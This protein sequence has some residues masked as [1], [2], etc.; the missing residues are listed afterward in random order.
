MTERI[1]Y[2]PVYLAI[3]LLLMTAV[4]AVMFTVAPLPRAIVYTLFWGAVYGAGLGRCKRSG[5]KTSEDL[6]QLTNRCAVLALLLFLGGFLFSGIEAGFILMLITLQAGRNLVLFTRRDLNFACLT[7]LI[8]LLFGAAKAMAGHFL[9]FMV[10]YALFAIFTFMAD[11]IDVRLCHA[12]GGDRD[13]LT[14]RMNLPVK[15]V[16]LAVMTL[17]LALAI[18]LLVP[19][20]ASP[21]VQAFPSSSEWNYDNRQWKEEAL[22]QR[23][24]D[25]GQNGSGV[26]VSGSAR[27]AAAE[28]DAE[29]VK[30]TGSEYRGFHK[31]LDVTRGGTFMLSNNVVL[32]LQAENALYVRGKVFDSFDGR[33]WE[34]SRS[35]VEKRYD[36]NG[37]FNFGRKPQAGDTLQVFTIK[38]DLPPF[39]FAAYRPVLVSFPGNVIETDGTLAMRVPDRLRKGTIYSVASHVEEVDHHPCSGALTGDDT[40]Q[41]EDRRYVALYP[42]IPDRIGRLAADITRGAGSDLQ[43][44]EAVEAYLRNNYA[45]T[46]DTI[47]IQWRDDPVERFLFDLKAGHCE[48]FA[49]SMVMMLRTLN[50]PARLA[51]GFYVHR[52]NPV[53]G[54]FEVREADGHAWV[55]AYL[56]RYGWVTF[57]PTSGFQLPQRSHRLFVAGTLARYLGDRTKE[58]I[59]KNRNSLWVKF[60]M[61]IRP[62]LMKIWLVITATFAVILLKCLKLGHWF[63]GGGW[64]SIVLLFLAV[65]GGW[66]LRRMLEPAWRMAGLRRKRSGDPRQFLLS[67]YREMERHFGSRGTP[68]ARPMTPLEYELL[69]AGRFPALS[70]KIALITRLFEQAAYGVVPVSAIEAGAALRAFEDIRRWKEPRGKGVGGSDII[71]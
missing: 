17:S 29:G 65:T 24:G 3:F 58:L 68:R 57:E 27:R 21:R 13:L 63:L 45:Y 9:G 43:R 55:E 34:G 59:R 22:R 41:T 32:Y 52:Y 35:G 19:R 66:Y 46:L 54:Y 12:V 36:Q 15:G 49:S 5:M 20:P 30:V 60:L 14:R 48:L 7:S 67:C 25:Q 18:Y 53:T 38:H 26:G 61:K 44:A 51:T 33:G 39:L 1:Q 62:V 28:E 4:A 64:R 8:L 50:I 16:G 11:H 42:R 47:G 70:E 31:R 2:P 71:P 23:P 37:R 69:L 56:E 10:L 40:G 6:R